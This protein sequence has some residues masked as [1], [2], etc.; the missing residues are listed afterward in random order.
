MAP[1]IITRN[2]HSFGSDIWS[3][4]IVLLIMITKGHRPPFETGNVQKTMKRVVNKEIKYPEY[5]SEECEDFLS[6]MFKKKQEERISIRELKQHSWWIHNERRLKRELQ[7]RLERV[8]TSHLRDYH[9]IFPALK[10]QYQMSLSKARI[11]WGGTTFDEE[12]VEVND[13]G[14]ITIIYG[15][16]EREYT[17]RSLP[18]GF[19]DKY[20]ILGQ[21]VNA[22]RKCSP[23]IAISIR[24]Q[25][26]E[27]QEFNDK[28]HLDLMFNGDI[29]YYKNGHMINVTKWM[30]E[31]GKYH[32]F[33]EDASSGMV[34]DTRMG[35]FDQKELKLIRTL[36]SQLRSIWCPKF[37]DSDLNP[38]MFPVL[39]QFAVF[40]PF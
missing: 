27:K 25:Q 37:I 31:T 30:I 19:W 22:H 18:L 33:G 13:R 6:L 17:V 11:T 26:D 23:L 16:I 35:L 29:N 32:G 2:G 20:R 15:T 28:H 34:L 10:V 36:S 4:G 39:L 7:T 1:E 14:V 38:T 3:A 12:M 24:D 21:F 5:L 8:D 40:S 9:R